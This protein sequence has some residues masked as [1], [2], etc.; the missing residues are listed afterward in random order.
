M[1]EIPLTQGKVALVDDGDYEHLSQW[2]WHAKIDRHT[3][4]AKRGEY[5]DGKQTTVYMHHVIFGDKGVDH[6]DRNGLNNVRSNLRLATPKENSRNRKAQD[7]SICPFKGVSW[8]KSS[9]EWVARITVIGKTR[10]LG[11]FDSM[12]RAACAYDD[13]ARL[14]FGEFARLNFPRKETFHGA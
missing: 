11:Y 3:W 12:V 8:K 10:H 14:H 4:Y 1:K 9:G 6:I 13:A 7:N 5:H 2:K